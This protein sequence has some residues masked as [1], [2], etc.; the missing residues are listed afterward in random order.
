MKII[1]SYSTGVENLSFDI[2]LHAKLPIKGRI[3]LIGEKYID[4]TKIYYNSFWVDTLLVV[5]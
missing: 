2:F 4:G 5:C 1:Y 3:W